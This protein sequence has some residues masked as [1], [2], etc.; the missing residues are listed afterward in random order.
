MATT[1]LNKLLSQAGV[2]SRRAADELLRQGRVA[3]NGRYSST[4]KKSEQAEQLLRELVE[5]IRVPV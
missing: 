2:A 4:L 5:T 1:R 3:V